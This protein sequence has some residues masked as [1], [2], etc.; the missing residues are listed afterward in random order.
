MAHE[1][2]LVGSPGQKPVSGGQFCVKS[3]QIWEEIQKTFPEHCSFDFT[4][5]IDSSQ[6]VDNF[7][8]QVC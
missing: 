6:R 2:P 7:R 5:A 3:G 1:W 8:V 4:A